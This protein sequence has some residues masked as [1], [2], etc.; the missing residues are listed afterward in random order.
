MTLR[1]VV[2]M[3]FQAAV[4]E[5]Y[6]TRL[7]IGLSEML[8]AI[9]AIEHAAWGADVTGRDDHAD[10]AM[11]FDFADRAA[12]ETYRHHPAHKDFIVRFMRELPMEKTRIQFEF[13]PGRLHEQA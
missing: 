9:T 12:Y 7:D 13:D 8:A 2:L 10:Y 6:L 5:G 3:R 4:P 1:H 11:I